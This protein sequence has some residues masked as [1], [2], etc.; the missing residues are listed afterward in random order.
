MLLLAAL[1]AA[2]RS[3]HVSPLWAV[4]LVLPALFGLFLSAA[5]RRGALRKLRWTPFLASACDYAERLA[6]TLLSL[7]YPVHEPELVRLSSILT[8]MK[9]ALYATGVLLAI[10]GFVMQL[11][12]QRAA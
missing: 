6:I 3:A 4:D 1:R 12:R 11:R 8:V 2:G 10:G 7:H 9:H 5:I